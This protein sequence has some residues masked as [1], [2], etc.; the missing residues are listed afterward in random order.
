M[1]FSLSTILI[2]GFAIVNAQLRVLPLQASPQQDSVTRQ[3]IDLPFWDDFSRSGDTPDTTLWLYGPDIYVNA[4]ISHNPPTYK[5]ATF[6]GLNALGLAYQIENENGG[7]GDSLVSQPI[8]LSKVAPGNIN[9]VYLSFYWQEGGNGEQPNETDSLVLY[10]SKAVTDSTF[11]WDVKWSRIGGNPTQP[12]EQVLVHVDSMAYFHDQ[13]QFKFVSYSSLQGPFDTWNID[14]IY[15][16]QH[17][18]ENDFYELDQAISG[19]PSSLF[20][21]YYE[22]PANVF[23][24]NPSRYLSNQRF[25]I[26]NL[27]NEIEPDNFFYSIE[28]LTTGENFGTYQSGG[29]NSLNALEIREVNSPG[30]NSIVIPEQSDPLDSQVIQSTFRFASENNLLIETTAGGNAISYPIDLRLNDTLRTSYL[31]QNYYAYDDGTAEFAV[32]INGGQLAVKYAIAEADTLTHFDVYFPSISPESTGTAIDLI[33]WT[34]LDNTG[35]LTR[36]TFTIR[37]SEGVN[38]FIR[39]PLSSPLLVSDTIYIGFEQVTENYIGIGFDRSN[40]EATDKIYTNTTGTWDQNTQHVGALML[41]PVFSFDSA[42]YLSTKPKPKSLLAYP[43]P[44]PG[45]V[46]IN[47][48]YDHIAI[49]NLSGDLLYA[50]ED[51][52]EHQ[53]ILEDGIYLLKITHKSNIVTQKLI[54][55]NE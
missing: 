44:S 51:Q 33:V 42:F 41:R 37:Q 29:T 8:D 55:R 40:L 31:L 11:R 2:L 1:K 13:F 26:S 17:R 46:Q 20:S 28:N 16:N 5:T 39:V 22:L 14:Y 23:F 24:K 36:Q 21:P 34:D 30:F 38:K 19:S 15:L 50:S 45:V 27:E 9:S 4:T 48:P 18:D 12:F 32:G 7:P 3:V 6:D 53:L 49:F 47:N 54:I 25:L 52:E 43:N 10:F 35:I